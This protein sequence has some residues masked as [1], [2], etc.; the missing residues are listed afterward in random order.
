MCR[1]D[2]DS[3]G[4]G[5]DILT[6]RS[7]IQDLVSQKQ[8]EDGPERRLP[9]IGSNGP[10]TG[11][12]LSA[13]YCKDSRSELPLLCKTQGAISQHAWQALVSKLGFR[14]HRP[15]AISSAICW[16][17]LAQGYPWAVLVDIEPGSS[18]RSCH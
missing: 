4:E 1:S 14:N 7:L 2:G 13:H 10:P 18:G 12:W 3:W 16:N 8:A 6:K 9:R 15:L 17:W 11:T 5:E